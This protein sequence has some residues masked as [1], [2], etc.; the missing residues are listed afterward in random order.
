MDGNREFEAPTQIQRSGYQ[1]VDDFVTYAKAFD[2]KHLKA[3][4]ALPSD[5]DLREFSLTFHRFLSELGGAVRE[6]T[7]FRR[8]H[9]KEYALELASPFLN[10]SDMLSRALL[11][12]HGYAGDYRLMEMVYDLEK[13][14]GRDPYKTGFVN[15]MD[16]AFINASTIKGINGRRHALANAISKSY[17]EK[18]DTIV[19]VDIACGGARYIRDL[20]D[21]G[22]DA[23]HIE[24]YGLDQD[25]AAVNFA[26]DA[27]T[28]LGIK[29]T[30]HC[31]KITSLFDAFKDVKADYFI[32]LGL[33]DYLDEATAKALI[34]FGKGILTENG[35][36]FLTNQHPD[37]PTIFGQDWFTDWRL[38]TRTEE[39]LHELFGDGFTVRTDFDKDMG[40]VMVFAE[41]EA[42]DA[43]VGE[44]AHV[45][46]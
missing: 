32:S 1:I 45:P 19:I 24:Y 30:V 3:T 34:D 17:A 8:T 40:F 18:S 37:D 27:L 25:A 10:R 46:A 4:Q 5:E 16:F 6:L 39:D 44:A 35:E 42:I 23:K 22:V 36:I 14:A 11:K 13:I 12:P 43:P 26:R 9:L 28:R 41:K 15:A 38:I 21:L 29:N 31:T 7:G 2:R 20:V 33:F